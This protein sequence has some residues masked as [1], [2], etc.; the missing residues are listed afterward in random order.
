MKSGE[1]IASIWITLP[2]IILFPIIWEQKLFFCS[3]YKRI[4][5]RACK[6]SS[7]ND[8]AYATGLP[9]FVYVFIR[10]SFLRPEKQNKF[11]AQKRS[12]KSSSLFTFCQL[13]NKQCD[14]MRRIFAIWADFWGSCQ[15]F[16]YKI[17]PIKSANF[18]RFFSLTYFLDFYLNKPFKNT[19]VEDILRLKTFLM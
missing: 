10:W 18:L 9:P 13:Q 5:T 7:G 6:M 8:S 14:Q 12:N 4:R 17:R 15:I 3:V 19:F 16:C 11:L 1:V 2:L